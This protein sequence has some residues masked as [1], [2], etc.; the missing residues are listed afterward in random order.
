[1]IQ[2]LLDNVV[3]EP[4]F[5]SFQ[6][7]KKMYDDSPIC[8]ICKN[9]IHSLEDATV[10]HIIPYSKNGKTAVNNGQLSHRSC[11][12]SKNATLPEDLTGAAQLD[13]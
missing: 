13:G 6:I 9:Q 4:R 5:F 8:A 12:A 11:N 2:P 7:R 10:D 3:T 1:M